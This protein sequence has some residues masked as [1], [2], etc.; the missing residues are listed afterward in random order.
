MA[1]LHFEQHCKIITVNT[2]SILINWTVLCRKTIKIAILSCQFGTLHD[3]DTEQEN[4]DYSMYVHVRKCT[5]QGVVNYLLL[6]SSHV[7]L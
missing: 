3:W 4:I 6:S 7:N 1:E 2:R 5:V